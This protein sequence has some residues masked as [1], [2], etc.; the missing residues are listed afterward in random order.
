MDNYFKLTGINLQEGEPCPIKKMCY[1]CISFVN[2]EDGTGSCTNE[3]V[4]AKGKEKIIASLP[5]GFEIEELKLKPMKLKDPSK[6]CGQYFVAKDFVC[7]AIIS[8]LS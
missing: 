2:N 8:L 1:N 5:E 3:T 4:N 7:D 6:K